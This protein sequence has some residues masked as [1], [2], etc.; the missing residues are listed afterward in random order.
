MIVLTPKRPSLRGNTFEKR[1]NRFSAST[2][3]QDREKGKDR[4]GQDMT[5][6][7]RSVKTSSSAIAERPHCKV[8]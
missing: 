8:G 4:T 7:D 2:W 1:E 3:S 6:Q 5:G